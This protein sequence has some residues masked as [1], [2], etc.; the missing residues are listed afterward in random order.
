MPYANPADAARARKKH[1]SCREMRR[2]ATMTTEALRTFYR[3]RKRLERARRRV[4]DTAAGSLAVGSRSKTWFM[5]DAGTVHEAWCTCHDCLY[6]PLAVRQGLLR[7][8]APTAAEATEDVAHE[9]G[10]LVRDPMRVH[11][12]GGR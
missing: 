4:R 7:G 12:R 9:F 10:R 1:N 6:G 2:R 8:V 11:R 3:E 5:D